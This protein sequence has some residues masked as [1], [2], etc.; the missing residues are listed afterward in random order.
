[1]SY[2][3]IAK[4]IYDMLNETD[5]R[6]SLVGKRNSY[7]EFRSF[8]WEK[9]NIDELISSYK[10]E[11]KSL[12]ENN[13]PFYKDGLAKFLQSEEILYYES[14][15]PL[16]TAFYLFWMWNKEIEFSE[17]NL[18]KFIQS[19]YLGT[20]GYK[21]IDV[22]SDK[23]DFSPELIF[24]GFYAIKAAEN[25]LRES[26]GNENTDIALLKYFKI[27]A[28]VECFEKKNRWKDTPFSWNEVEKL[29]NKAAPVY[30]IYEILFRYAH[31]SDQKISELMHAFNLTSA[32]LQIVDDLLDAK[33]DLSNGYETLVMQGYYSQFGLKEEISDENINKIL[34][35]ERLKLIYKTVHELF[36]K[37]RSIFEKHD[38]YIFLLTHEIQ[39]FNI[40]SLITIE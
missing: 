26:F 40:N 38:E 35:E 20:F 13:L 11:T 34:N 33:E 14:H 30:M 2:I 9:F 6:K 12:L 19:F 22:L 25:L 23:K 37:A 10:S 1:M 16:R 36:D 7:E 4:K 21:M 31:Y 3:S 32:A 17:A 18:K 8:M 39:F 27:Y 24:V 28:D 15:M 29:G 5:F